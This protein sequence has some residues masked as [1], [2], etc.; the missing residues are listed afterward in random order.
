M[1][2]QLHLT[3]RIGASDASWSI[4]SHLNAS[5]TMS[6]AYVYCTG[7]EGTVCTDSPSEAVAQSASGIA[8]DTLVGLPVVS[9]SPAASAGPLDTGTN[10]ISIPIQVQASLSPGFTAFPPSAVFVFSLEVTSVQEGT[11][12][13][14]VPVVVQ[15][16][17]PSMQLT[18]RSISASLS[19]DALAASSTSPLSLTIQN[20]GAAQG[21][22]SLAVPAAAACWLQPAPGAPCAPGLA[23]PGD[24]CLALSV[25]PFS[26]TRFTLSIDTTR[27]SAGLHESSLAV[28]L[29]SV[30]GAAVE[31]KV[32]IR[33]LVTSVAL[34]PFQVRIE[35]LAA[36]TDTGAPV[37]AQLTAQGSVSLT[38]RGTGPMQV[39]LAA[40]LD[41]EVADVRAVIAPPPLCSSTGTA[42]NASTRFAQATTAFSSSPWL[43][44]RFAG[45]VVPPDHTVAP[46]QTPP[47]ARA[48]LSLLL[49]YSAGTMPALGTYAATIA[50]VTNDTLTGVQELHI[51]PVAVSTRAG[52]PSVRSS[53][54]YVRRGPFDLRKAPILASG[55]PTN[56]AS[57]SAAEPVAAVLAR[58]SFGFP[59]PPRAA[60]PLLRA[61]PAANSSWSPCQGPSGVHALAFTA[62]QLAT[63][64]SLESMFGS[65]P[66]LNASHLVQVSSSIA[67]P[68][69]LLLGLT[70]V[71]LPPRLPLSN[72]DL[73]FQPPLNFNTSEQH[74]CPHSSQ[75]IWV[76][77]S[78]P[79]CSSGPEG[80]ESD[81]SGMQCLCSAGWALQPRLAL[82]TIT[83]QTLVC[84]A[85]LPGTYGPSPTLRASNAPGVCLVC[86]PG[87][88][89]GKAWSE[90]ANCPPN[91][92]CARG[93]I[94]VD[95]GFSI[96]VRD[97]TATG[98]PDLGTVPCPNP[99]A[100]LPRRSLPEQGVGA[101][102]VDLDLSSTQQDLII[103]NTFCA[104]GHAGGA[105]GLCAECQPG[106]VHNSPASGVH[107]SCSSCPPSE[108][109]ILNL[110]AAFLL[111]SVLLC[112]LF[113]AWHKGYA[114][115]GYTALLKVQL[116][117]RPSVRSRAK[118]VTSTGRVRLGSMEECEAAA[119]ALEVVGVH[120]AASDAAGAVLAHRAAKWRPTAA[121]ANAFTAFAAFALVVHLQLHG[122]LRDLR[123][124]PFHEAGLP[125]V[126][127][128][129]PSLL[130][131]PN[132]VSM[133]CLW[134]Q[135]QSAVGRTV[136]GLAF[137]ALAVILTLAMA[138]GLALLWPAA[139]SAKTSVSRA[140]Q[141]TARMDLIVA[142]AAPIAVWTA[143]PLGLSSLASGAWPQVQDRQGVWRQTADFSSMEEP[144]RAALLGI[145]IAALLFLLVA[146]AAVLWGHQWLPS[147]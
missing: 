93:S 26:A 79:H 127:F 65:T 29:P 20:D 87:T 143:V 140:G 61:V 142:S 147:G 12:L 22:V 11:V 123:T 7:P 89:S 4:S 130:P 107:G 145:S 112:A 49:T 144:I 33:V 70:A 99:F 62:V 5:M 117:E 10:I 80:V 39:I 100:C 60:L 13:A 35:G 121:T 45:Q 42:S 126:L 50:L 136:F 47:G 48:E 73:S 108:V 125:D 118:S 28:W 15:V 98:V 23:S 2:A 92:V 55:V 41:A 135:A 14:A 44:L 30:P 124:N 94:H 32:D 64:A 122:L 138:F 105:E 66:G 59:V 53:V 63:P 54:F 21:L 116:V 69:P 111:S 82:Q 81:S 19:L 36:P 119:A 40:A 8:P 71:A 85:C 72:I 58:D 16:R 84:D 129:V 27:L 103:L 95:A 120:W 139:K 146:P 52:R 18:P 31:S 57:F 37:A 114:A 25:A 91:T 106:W 34:C 132:S 3:L 43:G 113:V 101:Q 38:N 88:F 74:S 137:P 56:P 86:P 90:C 110:C 97:D 115:A 9:L 96:T 24:S 17:S 1:T 109:L 67:D 68:S 75:E 134:P 141:Q 133:A 77:V 131:S 102:L 46:L 78:A 83:P 76:N 128:G 6:K 104:E 51:V